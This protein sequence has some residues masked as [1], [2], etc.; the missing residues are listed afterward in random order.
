MANGDNTDDMDTLQ[1]MGEATATGDTY[2]EEARRAAQEARE[3]ASRQ[4]AYTRAASEYQR[5]QQ[6][7]GKRREL[8]SETYGKY[9][10]RTPREAR[11]T[12][13]A[14]G[15]GREPA[16][17]DRALGTLFK[18]YTGEGKAITARGKVL[19]SEYT[20]LVKEQQAI[21][22]AGKAVKARYEKAATKAREQYLVSADLAKGLAGE[23][24]GT[25]YVYD[26]KAG[27]TRPLSPFEEAAADIDPKTGIAKGVLAPGITD[28]TDK[29]KYVPPEIYGYPD[30]QKD[31]VYIDEG[32]RPVSYSPDIG[33]KPVPIKEVVAPTG[34]AIDRF[35]LTADRKIQDYWRDFQSGIGLARERGAKTEG[36]EKA[37]YKT[38]EFGGQFATGVLYPV[39][40][41]VGTAVG[42]GTLLGL[43]GRKKMGEEWYGLGTAVVKDPFGTTGQLLGG[44]AL[45]TT[46]FNIPAIKK[47]ISRAG[48][49]AE[50]KIFRD[51]TKVVIDPR[52]GLPY[53]S[54]AARSIIKSEY[55]PGMFKWQEPSPIT[56]S[57]AGKKPT[58]TIREGQT[59][60]LPKSEFLKPRKPGKF[61]FDIEMKEPP[62]APTEPIQVF[63]QKGRLGGE[64]LA[65][66]I[67]PAFRKSK[68]LPLREYRP[69][70]VYRE[71]TYLK[72]EYKTVEWYKYTKPKKEKPLAA[73]LRSKKAQRLIVERPRTKSYQP[74]YSFLP[75]DIMKTSPRIKSIQETGIIAKSKSG[76]LLISKTKTKQ[77]T[78]PRY[79]MEIKP[80]EEYEQL[81]K[82]RIRSKQKIKVG[83]ISKS[84]QETRQATQLRGLLIQRYKPRPQRPPKK[85]AE[86][87]TE[88]PPRKKTKI[89]LKGIR[90]PKFR[91]RK[92]KGEFMTTTRKY[93]YKPSLVGL[94]LKPT[95]K[96]VPKEFTGFEVRR[97]RI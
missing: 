10:K 72:P 90:L 36:L 49:Y 21:T 81:T 54:T 9:V 8:F 92:T 44:G 68:Q 91:Q 7:F 12:G 71:K 84:I 61:Q 63:A 62:R 56:V 59:T 95:R 55:K 3:L 25:Q 1:Q 64:K 19:K 34:G 11:G 82:T 42:M 75:K 33:G 89:L 2:R 15:M 37:A 96:K 32:G 87:I 5:Q 70:K 46:A 78:A 23:Y 20:G 73:L 17:D 79:K 94:T 52:T 51:P 22:A 83:V 14:F 97:V 58:I 86:V 76:T 4:Q 66:F 28:T 31:M 53:T 57:L 93:A 67:D 69:K 24:Q 80:K 26:I 13:Y 40:D 41:P 39:Y 60:L 43:R 88:K 38:I 74:G 85:P 47:P 50:S 65:S 45:F 35:A 27:Q 48:A 18:R 77:I 30:F 16:K 29:T 6:A